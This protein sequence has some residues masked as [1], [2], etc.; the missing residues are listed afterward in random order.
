MV[1]RMTCGACHAVLRVKGAT[2]GARGNCPNCRAP[3]EVPGAS[4]PPVDAE[5]PAPSELTGGTGQAPLM[6]DILQGFRGDIVP[7]RRTATYHVTALVVAAAVLLL[8]TI[9]LALI[10]AVAV[11]L[12]L[13]VTMSLGAVAGTHSLVALV[14]FYVGPLVAGAV[15]LFF[16]VKPLFARRSRARKLRTLE[17]GQ[18]PLLFALVTRVARAVGAPE[19]KRINVDCQVNA[20]AGFGGWFGVLFGGDLVLTVGLPF[21]GGLSVQQFAGVLAHE[22]GHFSQG[23]G[24]RL[25]CVVRSVNGW[26][27][28]VVYERD[29]WDE[30]LA[31]GIEEGGW[32]SLLLLLA[33]LCVWLTRGILWLLMV[34]GHAA[35]GFLLRQMEYDADRYEV[36]LAG[37]AAFEETS[38]RLLRL[39]LAAGTAYALAA[40]EWG[41]AGRLPDDLSALVAAV[42]DSLPPD[43]VRKAERVAEKEQT[44]VFD[45]HPSLSDR[46]ASARRDGATGVFHMGGPAVLLFRDFAG[47]SRAATRDFFRAVLGKRARRA[48]LVSPAE[49]LGRG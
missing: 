8:P 32:L 26:F 33:A 18:E 31:N 20:S 47:L 6:R 10:G 16:L 36:R 12:F 14:L 30:A 24:M 46:L 2:A 43:E 42:A 45:T 44:G 13:H 41:R 37:A 25:S 15:L 49:L 7:V 28:R 29:D 22:L 40:A 9:Y 19:P 27:V 23:A 11:L 38:R 39:N 35:S 48:T 1:T 3:V 5:A 21:C 34:A 4:A 17:F